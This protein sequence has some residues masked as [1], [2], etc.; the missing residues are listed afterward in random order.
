MFLPL[1]GAVLM[2]HVRA[3]VFLSLLVACFPPGISVCELSGSDSN[4]RM[5]IAKSL[6]PAPPHTHTL[7]L[8]HMATQILLEL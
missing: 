8:L 3:T 2:L 4:V 7:A 6:C 5:Q 1:D